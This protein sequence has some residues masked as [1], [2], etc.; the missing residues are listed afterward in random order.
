MEGLLPSPARRNLVQIGA[1]KMSDFSIA[2]R[3]I[4]LAVFVSILAQP[5]FSL[6]GAVS[7]LQA[8]AAGAA[9]NPAISARHRQF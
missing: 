3:A 2:A 8:V 6:Y 7:D 9:S 5:V 4:G 1:R